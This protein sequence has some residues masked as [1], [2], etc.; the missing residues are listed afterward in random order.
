MWAKAADHLS[1]YLVQAMRREGA[2]GASY[3]C[4]EA[5]ACLGVLRQVGVPPYASP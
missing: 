2:G 5:E 1:K 4:G 3:A